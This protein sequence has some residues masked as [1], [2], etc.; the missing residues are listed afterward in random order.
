MIRLA[1]GTEKDFIHLGMVHKQD[2][3]QRHYNHMH[4]LGNS[5]MPLLS[6]KPLE[7]PAARNRIRELVCG[8]SP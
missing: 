3:R 4:K 7:A 2:N 1:A 5:R 8:S 6:N